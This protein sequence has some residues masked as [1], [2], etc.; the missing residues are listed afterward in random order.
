MKDHQHYFL[1]A[2]IGL[3]FKAYTPMTNEKVSVVIF[4]DW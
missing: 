3:N 2:L 1:I 4:R